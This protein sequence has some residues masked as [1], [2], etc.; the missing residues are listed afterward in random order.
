MTSDRPYV[1]IVEPRKQLRESLKEVLAETFRVL[2]G[3]TASGAL[4]GFEHHTPKV[5]LLSMQQDEC[6]GFELCRRL[7]GL[8][9]SEQSLFVVYGAHPPELPEYAREEI[10][11]QYGVG[12]YIPEGATLIGLDEIAREHLRGNWKFKAAQKKAE[13]EGRE[14]DPRWDNPFTS[15]DVISAKNSESDVGGF[16]LRKLFRRRS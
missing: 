1:M 3:Q 13:S 10:Q 6:T 9:N 11:E 5:V 8:P 7:S 16:S 15:T 2:A 14:K 4:V 12:R